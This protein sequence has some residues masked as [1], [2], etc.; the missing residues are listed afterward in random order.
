MLGVL[1]HSPLARA[2]DARCASARVVEAAE[3]S[4]SWRAAVGPLR[5]ELAALREC[6]PSTLSIAPAPGGVRLTLVT[7]DG[8]RAERLVTSPGA[9]AAV[10]IGLVASIPA[11]VAPSA[12]DTVASEEAPEAATAPSRAREASNPAELPAPLTA[13]PARVEAGAT[14]GIRV[15]MPTRLLVP[16]I[17]LRADV[18]VEGWFLL[19]AVRYAPL[20]MR[21]ATPAIPGYVYD[22]VVV[23]IGAGRRF[24]RPPLV[25]DTAVA[26]SLAVMTE[27]GDIPDGTGGT[28]SSARVAA[29]ARLLF[30]RSRA[31]V[32]VSLSTELAPVG[33]APTV[34]PTLPS[35]PTWSVGVGVGVVGDVL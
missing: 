23:S 24:G 8:H 17:E 21:F 32:A 26:T 18:L 9:L 25:L 33:V 28:T 2:D 16:D 4:A 15:A 29:N 10:A 31:R 3:L 22:E 35:L 30:G 7:P 13:R 6:L 27:E 14:A 5:E 1:L 12:T 20:G 19:A 11:E 34:D